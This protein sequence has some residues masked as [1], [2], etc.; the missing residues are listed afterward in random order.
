MRLNIFSKC[1]KFYVDS[2]NSKKK[3]KKK[4]KITENFFFFKI[5][6]FELVAG[7]STFFGVNNFQNT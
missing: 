3:K 5:N 6:T 4:K 1:S 2:Q 7:N